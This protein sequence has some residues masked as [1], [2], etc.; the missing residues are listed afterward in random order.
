MY[1]IVE[2]KWLT[3]MICY[4]K[5]EAKEIAK[6]SKP[7]QFLILKTDEKGE[8]IPLT[9][10]DYDSKEG[11]ISIVFQ[12]VGESTKQMGR[13]E[14][15]DSFADVVGPL[16]VPS[17]FLKEEII[18]KR[19]ITRNIFIIHSLKHISIY[20]LPF[21]YIY[22]KKYGALTLKDIASILYNWIKSRV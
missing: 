21:I 6:A 13:L 16:G 20:K 14:V 1:R 7:G 5:I 8:R 4:M 17:E 3:T 9:L 2:K 10:C 11:T 12:V 19:P 15:G 18:G 22:L